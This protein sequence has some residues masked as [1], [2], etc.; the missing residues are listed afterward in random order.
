MNTTYTLSSP[1]GQH[2]REQHRTCDWLDVRDIVAAATL[3]VTGATDRN[4]IAVETMDDGRVE[5]LDRFGT[6]VIVAKKTHQY[7][8]TTTETAH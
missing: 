4:V 7:D 5:G 1:F 3:Y 2:I 8:D 6:V